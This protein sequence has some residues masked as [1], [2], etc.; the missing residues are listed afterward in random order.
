MLPFSKGRRRKRSANLV[1]HSLMVVG[2][3]HEVDDGANHP[4]LGA[5]VSPREEGIQSVLVL[6]DPVHLA[7]PRHEAD[8]DDAP[9]LNVCTYKQLRKK[10]EC[11]TD[12]I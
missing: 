11:N 4:G 2:R 1:D 7:V 3:E 6:Q 8:P 5:G 10:S 12:S 9:L